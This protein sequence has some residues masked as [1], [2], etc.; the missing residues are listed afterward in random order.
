MPGVEIIGESAFEECKSLQSVNLPGTLKRI[1]YRAFALCES[2]KSIRIPSSVEEID[3]EAFAECG[4]IEIIVESGSYAD[5]IKDTL[6][7][8]L[9][10]NNK[11]EITVIVRT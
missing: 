7:M 4:D 2:L 5:K 8:S 1:G 6:T 3:T 10:D 9:P 11:K